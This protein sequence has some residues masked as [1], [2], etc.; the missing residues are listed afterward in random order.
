MS[1]VTEPEKQSVLTPA[2]ASLVLGQ[3]GALD[4]AAPHAS[5]CWTLEG[6]LETPIRF[7]SS[8]T[9]HFPLYVPCRKRF[10]KQFKT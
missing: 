7:E 3:G 9:D 10:L 8:N 6:A 4:W 2:S 1:L 5:V